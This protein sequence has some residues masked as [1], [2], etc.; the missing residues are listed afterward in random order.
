M[1]RNPNA[2]TPGAAAQEIIGSSWE[3]YA[4]FQDNLLAFREMYEQHLS[5][6]LLPQEAID[7]RGLT[8]EARLNTMN[9]ERA[10]RYGR[11]Y[12]PPRVYYVDLLRSLS[13]GGVVNQELENAGL[14]RFSDSAAMYREPGHLIIIKTHAFSDQDMDAYYTAGLLYEEMNHAGSVRKHLAYPI[15]ASPS[16]ALGAHIYRIGATVISRTKGRLGTVIDEGQHELEN[17][18]FEGEPLNFPIVDMAPRLAPVVEELFPDMGMKGKMAILRQAM[19]A[20]GRMPADSRLTAYIGNGR[21]VGSA[22]TYAAY[23]SLL[24]E[25]YARDPGLFQ[26]GMDFVYGDKMLAYAHAIDRQCGRGFL[27]DLMMAHTPSDALALLR[28]LSR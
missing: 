9:A 4:A 17:A 19:I 26:L 25:I 6:V 2:Y 14:D 15:P 7:A 1:T 8:F 18:L 12:S 20:A 28:R 27:H 16:G 21:I 22:N 3:P 23:R 24:E 11:S 13:I 5:P 10:A